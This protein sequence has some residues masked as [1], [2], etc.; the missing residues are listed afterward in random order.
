MK[1]I[2]VTLVLGCLLH[3]GLTAQ[4][5]NVRIGSSID[6]MMPNE[7]SVCINPQ[8][9]SEIL[10][11]ANADNYYLSKDGGLTWQ[12]GVLQSSFGVNCDPAIVCDDRGS[13]YFFHLV[14]DLS[15][16]VCQK[17]VSLAEP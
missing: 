7:P 3:S 4:H 5:I 15:R 14:P 11:G 6:G 9:T 13:F 8:N 2:T 16:V 12:H 17:K 1:K 10:V